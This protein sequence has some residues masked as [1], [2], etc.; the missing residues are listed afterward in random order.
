MPQQR[1]GAGVADL[2]KTIEILFEG[3]DL[4]SR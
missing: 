2:K 1:K 4:A 3:N